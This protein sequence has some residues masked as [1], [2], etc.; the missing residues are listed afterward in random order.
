MM[1]WIH[2]V[3]CMQRHLSITKCCNT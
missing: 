2:Y 3:V 1:D